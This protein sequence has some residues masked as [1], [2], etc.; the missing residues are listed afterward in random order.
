MQSPLDVEDEGVATE[1]PNGN[2]L[3]T[4]SMV[5]PDTQEMAPFE[6]LW[7]DTAHDDGLFLRSSDQD[8]WQGRVGRVQVALGRSNNLFWAWSAERDDQHWKVL[9]L[10]NVADAGQ[11]QFLPDSPA[12]QA[13]QK[14]EFNGKLWDV[15]DSHTCRQV[16][17]TRV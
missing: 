8:A 2:I 12:W 10:I 7:S 13:G 14:V 16:G 11:V 9:S 17:T 15:L 4:G 5:N 6:E 3:E 1:L